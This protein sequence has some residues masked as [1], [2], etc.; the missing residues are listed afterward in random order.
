MC[1]AET[2]SAEF[3]ICRQ[4]HRSSFRTQINVKINLRQPTNQSSAT[5]LSRCSLGALCSCD[6]RAQ[7]QLGNWNGFKISKWFVN[8]TTK[9][10]G[11]ILI[12]SRLLCFEMRFA[13]SV[14]WFTQLYRGGRWW[15]EDKTWWWG[16]WDRSNK[17]LQSVRNDC[18]YKLG[19]NCVSF[20][21][22][23]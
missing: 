5:A 21:Y 10:Y 23:L 17:W 8:V 2:P 9:T 19:H 18:L 20:V 14:Y 16:S 11:N 13:G 4:I 1:L 3:M 7:K 12:D 22:S 15:G 6:P